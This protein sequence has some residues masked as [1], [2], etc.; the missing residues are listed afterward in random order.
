MS[1]PKKT[2]R[3]TTPTKKTSRKTT[4][5]KKTKQTKKP[6]THAFQAEVGRVLDL[7]INSLYSHREIFLRELVSNSSDA[8]DKLRFRR[9]TEPGLGDAELP[10][11]IQVTADSE[12][13]TVTLSDTGIGMSHDD[14]VDH[15]G[16]VARS[17]TK[18]FA[19]ALETGKD[20]GAEGLI[21]QFGVGFYSAFLVADEVTV[22]SRAAGS[23][24]AW[25]WTSDAR[26]SFTLEPAERETHGTSVT[27]K[28]GED[29]REFTSEWR[30]R[31]LITSY[32]D[33]LHHPIELEVTRYVGEGED[34]TTEQAFEQVNQAT[35]LWMRSKDDISDDEY[36]EF[37]KH[38][39][40]DF[41][42]PLARNHFKVEGMQ[43]FNA[44]LYLPSRAPFDL[45]AREAKHGVRLYVKRV[46]IM[47]ECEELLP[48]WLRFVRGLVDSDDLPLNI[49]REILQD[50]RSVQV[51]AK[52][53]TKK[54]LDMIERL[55]KDDVEAYQTFWEGF[56]VALKE[57][58]HMASEYKDRLAELMRF[59]SSVDADAWTSLAEYV[60]RMP[61]GQE[62]IYV[63]LGQS[64][65]AVA[66]SPHLEA[67]RAKGYEVLYLTDPIDEWLVAALETYGEKP[68][69]SAMK[70]DL[71]LDDEKAEGD[72]ADE[73]KTEEPTGFED[74]IARFASVLDER[75]SEVKLSKR[76]VDSPACLVVGEGG[77]HAHI[78]R[79]VRA[80]DPSFQIP[81]SKRIL[82]LNA[83]HAVVTELNSLAGDE[84]RA[85]ELDRWVE[86]LYN[87]CLLAEGSPVTD[88]AGF[89]SQVSELMVK[90]LTP[91]A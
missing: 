83:D 46:F 65:D 60:E 22:V 17:G 15:L 44:L 59:R 62:S 32:S 47:D 50:S 51:I 29:H 55:A 5:T 8:L 63:I 42:G 4:S 48:R 72:D 28:L 18:A 68:I 77:M 21:G 39:T 89:A 67:L 7:V 34:A 82:E 66:K 75:V 86:L 30:L 16:T 85:E 79:M 12:A 74:L 53:L 6:E 58:V 40:K 37:Y 73:E 76:L 13:G 3:K 19:D 64:V 81:E 84:A 56:G 71:G 52:Q 23:D 69:V 20:E 78:E 54:S 36:E 26:E 31:E 41:E 43:L 49:S 80:T 11:H 88:P 61:D 91:P 27:L 38:I 57:G 10:L 25:R 45:F 2:S 9:L 14:L 1:A 70:A 24:E 90:A 35:A 87:H 33:Y